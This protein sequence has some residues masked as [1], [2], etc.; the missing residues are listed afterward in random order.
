MKLP[1]FELSDW[2]RKHLPTVKYNF[3]ES[4][5]QPPDFAEAGIDLDVEKF[6][7]RHTGRVGLEETLAETFDVEPENV[8]VTSSSSEAIYLAHQA[9]LKQADEVIVPVPNYP[10]QLKLPEVVRAQLRLLELSFEDSWKLHPE[11]V[12]QLTS[13]GTRLI[14]ITSSH[15]PSGMQLSKQTLLSLL[16]IAED[17]NAWLLS[18]EAFREY[19]F[20]HAPPPAATLSE[21]GISTGTMSKFYGVE[22]IRI[23]WVL[24]QPDVVKRLQ[25]LKT[26]ITSTNSH[27]GEYIAKQVLENHTWFF[28]RARGFRERNLAFVKRFMT[29]CQ[30]LKWIEPEASL[31][32]FPKILTGEPSIEFCKR[33]L[34]QTGVLLDPGVYFEKE[35]YLRICFTKNTETVTKGLGVLE[36]SLSKK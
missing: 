15:N 9:L 18:D 14:S 30:T 28:E 5:I 31:Y 17:A 10:A 33:I 16:E 36:R 2:I 1:E 25:Q 11:E 24:A 26:W 35:G 20:E 19:G 6:Y 7:S 3:A 34:K 29:N 27:F 13:T 21:R 23:G 4:G 8:L 32:G 22:D 12:K